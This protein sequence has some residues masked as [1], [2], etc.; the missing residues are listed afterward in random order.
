M[1]PRTRALLL[2]HFIVFLWGFTGILGKEL[3][4]SVFVLVALRMLI[5]LVSIGLYAMVAKKSLVL[6]KRDVLKLIGVGVLTSCHWCAFFY[7]IHKSNV[8][9]TLS[10]ISTTAFFVALISPFFN[11]S[12]LKLKELSLGVLVIVGIAI[13]FSSGFQYATGI[14]YSLIAALLAAVFSSFNGRFIQ[15]IPA[16]P[17]AF[18]EM[19]GGSLVMVGMITWNQ[20]WNVV[21]ALKAYDWMLLILL[22]TATT[23]FAFIASVQ[24]MKHLSPFTCA[25]AINLEPVYTIVFALLI[26]GSSEYMSGVFYFG[27]AI[28]LIALFAESL[29]K[30]KKSSI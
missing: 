4:F 16:T 24:V 11:K 13:I 18:Y 3:H 2:L 5:A 19:L 14:I 27:A 25:M 1:K 20:E 6:P 21:S 22:G 28:I 7:S 12:K 26:Y 30:N 29:L 23:A 10:V 17:I 15:R 9:T 8:S